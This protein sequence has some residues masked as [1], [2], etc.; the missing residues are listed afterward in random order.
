MADTVSSARA[1]MAGMLRAPDV[2]VYEDGGAD[3]FIF[4]KMRQL[5]ALNRSTAI[6]LITDEY[7]ETIALGALIAGAHG[8][9]P[10]TAP[11]GQL[12]DSVRS[13]AS[14]GLVLPALAHRD[15]VSWLAPHFDSRNQKALATLTDRERCVLALLKMG[16]SNHDIGRELHIAEAT[17][18][19]HLTHLLRKLGVRSRLEAALYAT[20]SREREKP[21]EAA[22]HPAKPRLTLVPECG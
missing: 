10:A 5:S 9:Q 14:G 19:K 3:H 17:V 1:T 4:E 21:F 7:S 18:K 11:P 6:L 13:V 16:L 8:Y 2:V 12:V 15:L 20:G 22:Q